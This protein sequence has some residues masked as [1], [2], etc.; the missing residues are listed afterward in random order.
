MAYMGINFLSLHPV[1][2]QYILTSL[3]MCLLVPLEIFRDVLWIPFL[4]TRL[5]ILRY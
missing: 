1:V 3:T 5:E 4:K 2:S